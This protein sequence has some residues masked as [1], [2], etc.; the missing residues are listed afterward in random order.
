MSATPYPVLIVGLPRSMTYWTAQTLGYDHDVTAWPVP[1]RKAG[2]CETALYLLPETTRG[3]YVDAHTK[4]VHL[5][6]PVHEV[7]ASLARQFPTVD[8]PRLR[9]CLAVSAQALRDFLAGRPHLSLPA[10]LTTRSLGQLAAYLDRKD[11]I[12]DW[13]DRLRHRHDRLAD[14][15]IHAECA[16]AL[17]TQG[18]ILSPTT[19]H[20]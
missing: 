18:L 3:K 4:I 16:A 10:P 20:P 19:S 14:P 15:A 13:A 5:A 2:L 12:L 8:R 1:A 6:R 17:A 7:E 11:E 9:E